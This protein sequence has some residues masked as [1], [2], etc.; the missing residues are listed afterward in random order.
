MKA[1]LEKSI[2]SSL[3]PEK[4]FPAIAHEPGSVWLDSSL[5][6]GDKGRYSFVAR[7]PVK[8][9]FANATNLQDR[10]TELTKLWQEKSMFSI[11]Y[12]SYEATLPFVGIKSKQIENL[13]TPLLHF[14]FYES[15]LQFDHL[16]G[17]AEAS[18][19]ESDD[20][21]D[22]LKMPFELSG[23]FEND[24]A[25]ITPTVSKNEYIE[26]VLAIKEHIKEG[27]IYQANFTC[28]FDVHSRAKPF[29]IYRNLRKLNP[30][31]YSAYLNFGD[32]QIISSSPERMFR[33]SGHHITTCPIKGTV[34]SGQNE[35]E[36]SAQREK[37][38][39]S[40]KDK[41]ELLMIVDLMRNDLG[42][43]ARTGSVKVSN[44][45]KIEEYSSLVHLVTD[46]SAT[47]EN[48]CDYTKIFSSLMPGGSI[49][50]AP[51]KRAVE[52][53]QEHESIPRGVYTG[54]IGYVN[55]DNADFNIAIRTMIH[56][57]EIYHVHAGGG[58]VADSDPES[59]YQEMQ[60]KAKNLFKALGL[61]PKNYHG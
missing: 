38:L 42:R 52:I 55:G 1:T 58:I 24:C 18:N 47:L 48:G 12:I 32:F 22:L 19:P 56:Q 33:R 53:L 54:C 6:I 30:A 11:G 34:P 51:K 8:E 17:N 10:F 4:I 40:S 37:L 36:R 29:G 14:L 39:D 43:T 27:D 31:P 49:T 45:F 60:L 35:V 59:E 25:E 13:S 3:S 46:V 44:L 2:K 20:Y 50:G 26:H 5:M 21:S 61:S 41:A 9:I 28:R 15:T 7:R 16:T 23:E 57:N